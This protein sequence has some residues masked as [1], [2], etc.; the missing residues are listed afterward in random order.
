MRLNTYAA[1]LLALCILCLAAK[2]E[3]AKTE[4]P[5]FQ[6]GPDGKVA[7]FNGKDF[8]GWTA[9]PK[10]WKVEN[11]EIVGSASENHDYS[12][13]TT[14]RAV[15]DFRLVVKI[16]LTPDKENSGIQVRS[17]MVGKNHM[18]GPQF[19]AGKGW[20]GHLYDEHGLALVTKKNGEE[21]VKPGEWN[22]YEIVCVGDKF[23]SAING[24]Q[25]VN[26]Q[27]DKLSRRGIIGFQLHSG[28]PQEVR[29]KEIE[30]ELNP[31][32]EL[33]TLKKP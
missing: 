12:Y 6:A 16:K 18:K 10:F 3:S 4:P 8:T 23:L 7:V 2:D 20:W 21:F 27:N 31:K 14:T 13:A 5:L 26:L 1:A 24:G 19:D 9:D 17:E 15:G 30:L 22:T 11:G 32:P 29:I 28:G 25:C 33:K